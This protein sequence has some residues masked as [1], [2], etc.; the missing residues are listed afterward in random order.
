MKTDVI[1]CPVDYSQCSSLAFDLVCKIAKPGNKV[2][3]LH[4][5]SEEAAPMNMEEAWLQRTEAEL[6]DQILVDNDI[7]VE[8]LTQVGDPATLIAEAAKRIRVDLIVMGT[9]GRSGIGRLLLGSVA[10]AVLSNVACNVIL[11]RPDS[12]SMTDD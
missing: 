3:L 11:V 1:L 2:I 5:R 6:R 8:H 10:Q 9:H 4:V 12:K 7:E